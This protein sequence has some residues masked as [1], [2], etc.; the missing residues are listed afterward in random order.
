MMF[1]THT[2]GEV[3]WL[4]VCF[5][6][7]RTEPTSFLFTSHFPSFCPPN[8]P[9]CRIDWGLKQSISRLKKLLGWVAKRFTLREEEV[10]LPRLNPWVI[11]NLHKSEL[12]LLFCACGS[13]KHCC[14]APCERRSSQEPIP[15]NI[16]RASSGC[17]LQILTKSRDQ[18]SVLQTHQ[19]SEIKDDH[20]L[21]FPAGSS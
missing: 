11:E 17:D 5:N 1:L 19:L 9:A 20:L 16:S 4:A 12:L 15:T 6:K 13:V 21:C 14:Q 2:D 18:T 10:Q 3:M 8:E 7:A